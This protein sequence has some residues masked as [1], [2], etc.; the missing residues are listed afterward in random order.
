M[1]YFTEDIPMNNKYHSVTGITMP[2]HTYFSFK[3]S[4]AA[5]FN[6]ESLIQNYVLF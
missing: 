6:K 2:H 5:M 4:M 1:K 3:L